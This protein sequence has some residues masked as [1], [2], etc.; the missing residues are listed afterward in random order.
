MKKNGICPI[1]GSNEIKGPYRA[2][3]HTEPV[4][5]AMALKITI[6]FRFS[7]TLETFTCA[8]CGYSEYF[9]DQKGL[10]NIRKHGKK[11]II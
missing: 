5:L 7:A 3:N 4:N 10:E 9:V 8:H 6:S 2:G 11:Y 1:C